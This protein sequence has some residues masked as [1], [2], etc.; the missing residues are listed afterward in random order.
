MADPARITLTEDDLW[1]C[2]MADHERCDTHDYCL[3]HE[4][5]I[6]TDRPCP[7]TVRRIERIL[8]DRLREERE[9]GEATQADEQCRRPAESQA[10]LRRIWREA[11]E[12]DLV[13]GVD[14]PRIVRDLF[15]SLDAAG[16][17]EARLRVLAD[18]W[19]CAC[20]LD[21]RPCIGCQIRF[22]LTDPSDPGGEQR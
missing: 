6:P 17:R 5:V 1:L 12:S 20:L 22:L 7:E 9:T 11:A 18:W 10:G 4:A 16:E 2:N 3:V 21:S 13:E 15:K 8:S 19:G 14:W